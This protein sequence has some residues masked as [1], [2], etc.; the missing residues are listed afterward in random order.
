MIGEF[1]NTPSFSKIVHA[2]LFGKTINKI[3]KT[4]K[5]FRQEKLEKKD[6]EPRTNKPNK[7]IYTSITR[8]HYRL[9]TSK[10]KKHRSTPEIYP[11]QNL[12]L[13]CKKKKKINNNNINRCKTL[14]PQ[15][16]KYYMKKD[17]QSYICGGEGQSETL[18]R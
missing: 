15:G 1:R 10:L 4:R 7:K 3:N 5:L 9:K 12:I 16:I 6:S 11:E 2:E 8:K 18:H 13:D 17:G 14:K